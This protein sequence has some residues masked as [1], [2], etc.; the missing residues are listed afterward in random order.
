MCAEALGICSVEQQ[1]VF[2]SIFSFSSGLIPFDH[3]YSV[4]DR[5]SAKSM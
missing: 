5:I 3:P 2:T 1:V 4:S